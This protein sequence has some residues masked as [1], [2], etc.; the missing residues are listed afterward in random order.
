MFDQE[1]YMTDRDY[2]DDNLKADTLV[3]RDLKNEAALSI[4]EVKAMTK[5]F[6]KAA[7]PER[8]RKP[9]DHIGAYKKI[10]Y[11]IRAEQ[12]AY[13]NT[14]IEL[15]GIKETMLLIEECQEA[16]KFDM[17]QVSCQILAAL[18]MYSNAI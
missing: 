16:Q 10:S 9:K 8:P 15:D 12:D 11:N 3:F 13:V 17:V 18:F 1:N 5:D 4:A 2:Y 14:F 7:N 6:K